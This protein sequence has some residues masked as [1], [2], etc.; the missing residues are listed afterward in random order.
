MSTDDELFF[1]VTKDLHQQTPGPLEGANL[2]IL[3][4]TAAFWWLLV[5]SKAGKDRRLDFASGGFFAVTRG[6]VDL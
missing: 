5:R 3:Q 4:Q 1:W 2:W 6:W